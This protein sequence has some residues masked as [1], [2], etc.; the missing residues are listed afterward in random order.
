MET[1][2]N[3]YTEAQLAEWYI[4]LREWLQD[5][6]KDYEDLVAPVQEQQKEIETELQKRLNAAEATS[7]RTLGGTIVRAKR[8]TYTAEDRNAYG[9][10]IIETGLWEATTIKPTKEYVEDYAREH[11]G[12][13][14]PG[15]A[16]YTVHTISIKK[17]SNK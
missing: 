16:A 7:F 2:L 13:L 1:P 8:V 4:N 11:N 6:K 3:E 15:V 10:H 17:P 9:K 14:P 5:R 12:Q